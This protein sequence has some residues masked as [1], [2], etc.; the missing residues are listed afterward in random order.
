MPNQSLPDLAGALSSLRLA[1]SW[2]Q[3]D[4]G[5]AAGTGQINEYE[6][7]RKT[8]TRKRLEQ[9][10]AVMGLPPEAIDAALDFQAAI[11]AMARAPQDPA[12][13]LSVTH[14]HIEVVSAR[15]GR[16]VQGYAR[17]SLTLLTAESQAIQARQ[18]AEVLW[19]HLKKRTPAERRKLVERGARFRTWALCERVAR[20]SI[21]SAP[22]EPRESLD[23]AD[24]ALLIA[25]RMEGDALLRRGLQGY[26]WAHV[27]NS[28]R[29]CNDLPG[30]EDAFARASKLWE[31]G[32]AGDPGLNPAW[33]PRLEASLRREQRRFSD[34]LKR[35]DEALA[36]DVEGELKGE[37][38]LSK[39]AIYEILG[40][41]EGSA[42][43]LAEAAPLIDP[44]REPRN[45]FGLRFNLLVG[46]CHLERFAEAETKLKEVRELAERLGGELDLT[47]VVWAG[48]KI[49]AGLGRTSEAEAAFQQ[50]RKVFE[51][52]ELTWDYAVVSLELAVILLEQG[53]TGET[54][55]L[56][57]EMLKIFQVQKVEREALA[58]LKVFCD[59]AKK[60]TATVER[61]RRI[62]RFLYRVQHDPELRF[63][64]ETGAE[65]R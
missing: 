10:V 60:E 13:G 35:V 11:R 28:R 3:V 46:L 31:A 39:S 59:A 56:A 43:A 9:I 25:D 48:A 61:T 17:S 8:L 27:S 23:L 38:L 14:R 1:L 18:Q 20:E 57:E 7:G 58:A 22:N 62:V 42:A 15:L 50:A 64:D 65:A 44:D 21:R 52:R 36:L 47:R 41:S 45:A 5:K 49:A 4:L 37:I 40:D 29:V 6:R 63:E 12:G 32:A 33:L 54:R 19:S 30:A 2:S 26:A 55:T 34:A 24:L 53:R 16:M 51:R